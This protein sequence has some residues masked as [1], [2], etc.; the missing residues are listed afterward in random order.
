MR[1]WKHTP[2]AALA[3]KR[4]SLFIGLKPERAPTEAVTGRQAMQEAAAAG[5]AVSE[6]RPDDP[7]LDVA[8]W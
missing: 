5:L 7:M 6:G 8:G 1:H 4:L 2:P 3:L